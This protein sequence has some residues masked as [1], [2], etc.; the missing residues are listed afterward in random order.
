ALLTRR[1]NRIPGLTVSWVGWQAEEH[2]QILVERS[3]VLLDDHQVVAVLRTDLP[4]S[5]AQGVQC[6]E[7]D[8]GS[9]QIAASQQCGNRSALVTLLGHSDFLEHACVSMSH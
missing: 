1:S 9:G 2:I 7:R 6:I 3:L 5:T 8:D 4:R